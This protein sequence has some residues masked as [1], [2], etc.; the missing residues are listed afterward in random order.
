ME[1]NQN[2]YCINICR[3]LNIILSTLTMDGLPGMEV[4]GGKI[5]LKLSQILVLKMLKD[6]Y[7]SHESFQSTFFQSLMTRIY[8]QLLV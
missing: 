3:L 7:N 4:I 6:F 5:Y 1:N 8:L 2:L